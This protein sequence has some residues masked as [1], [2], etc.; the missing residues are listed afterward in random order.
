M[1]VAAQRLLTRLS[2]SAACIDSAHGMHDDDLYGAGFSVQFCAVHTV[3]QADQFRHHLTQCWP[4][5][6]DVLDGQGD[7]PAAD[8]PKGHRRP[9]GRRQTVLGAHDAC[10]SG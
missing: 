4:A 2:C 9:A 6:D 10:G 8:R 5:A 1:L 7:R 3:T